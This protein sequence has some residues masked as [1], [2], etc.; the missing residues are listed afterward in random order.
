MKS[1]LF[2]SA[3]FNLRNIGILLLML[4]F[5]GVERSGVFLPPFLPYPDIS[6]PALCIGVYA[7]FVMQSVT[8][9]EFHEKFNRKRKIRHIQDLNYMCLKLSAEAKKHT[10]PTYLQ[11]LKK[12]MEDKNHIVNSFFRGEK[13]YLKERVVEQTLNLVVSYIRL[14]TNFC[15]RSRE[16]SEVDVGEITNRINTNMRKIN[17][18]KDPNALDD[19]KKVIEMDEKLIKRLKDEKNELERISA[20]LDYME[21]TVHMFKHQTISSIESEE[22]LEKLD[23][24]V[25]E[26]AALDS[27]L[28]ERRRNK[29]RL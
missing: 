3:L 5:I 15:I 23:M 20:K 9:K 19:V 4:G 24:A 8:S 26:A 14:L 25:N 12:V 27:V 17:F 7:A 1:K 18:I 10:N 28:E 22:M 2:L 16:L 29:L 13:G 21:T 6:G 11:K